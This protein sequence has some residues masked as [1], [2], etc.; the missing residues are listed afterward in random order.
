MVLT[1][2][3][4]I[5]GDPTGE[6]AINGAEHLGVSKEAIRNWIKKDVIPHRRIGKAIQV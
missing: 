1:C 5:D 3:E 6:G 4:I 2:D